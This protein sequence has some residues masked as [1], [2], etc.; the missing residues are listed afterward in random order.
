[1]LKNLCNLKL[2][3][4]LQTG[5]ACAHYFINIIQKQIFST[6]NQIY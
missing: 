1:M 2:T 6:M 4:I 5:I 3:E